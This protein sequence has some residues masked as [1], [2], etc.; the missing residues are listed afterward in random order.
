[1][2]YDISYSYVLLQTITRNLDTKFGVVIVFLVSFLVSGDD[3]SAYAILT[4]DSTPLGFGYVTPAS[5]HISLT[6]H[7]SL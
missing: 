6:G 1:M 5:T 2:D 4:V 7:V 3:V